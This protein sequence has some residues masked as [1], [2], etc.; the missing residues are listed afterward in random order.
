[1]AE[2]EERLES[3]METTVKSETIYDG[4][5]ITLKVNTVE[6][7]NMK[8]AKREIA[9]HARGV[10]IIALTDRGTMFMVR[11]YRAGVGEVLLEI[12][13]GLV[14]PGESPQEAAV[15]EL[16]EEIDRQPEK[17]VYLLD[18]YS[19]PGFTNEKLSLFLAQDLKYS[20]KEVDATEFLKVEE[21]P[22]E[23]LFEMVKN[24]DIVDAKS[25]IAIQHAYYECF[26]PNR[27]SY[28]KKRQEDQA[29]DGG[30]Q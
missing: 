16:Q 14:D 25:I 29:E 3:M 30:K 5:I 10:G 22:V 7:P 6:L 21:Y 8:Y 20:P 17:M 28:L 4:K 23:E 26:L 11:Q 9:L 13:A 15:R 12:P 19:S 18:A 27:E 1:M 2:K 24:F